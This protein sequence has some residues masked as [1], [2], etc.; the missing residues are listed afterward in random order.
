LRHGLASAKVDLW[1]GVSIQM[2]AQAP[3]PHIRAVKLNLSCQG[4]DSRM[5]EAEPRL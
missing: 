4:Y 3:P 5:R 1:I 2:A